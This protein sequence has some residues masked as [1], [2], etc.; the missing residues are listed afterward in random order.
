MGWA[1]VLNG[2]VRVQR[3]EKTFKQR[4]GYPR[5][6]GYLGE[7]CSRRRELQV[8]RPYSGSVLGVPM[9]YQDQ[10]AGA[11]EQEEEKQVVKD[12]RETGE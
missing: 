7:E 11:N 9:Q 8:A 12:V 4:L 1:V 6:C 10:C 5:L 2:V 3:N